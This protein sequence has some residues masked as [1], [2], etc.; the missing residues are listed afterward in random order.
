MAGRSFGLFLFV[1]AESVNG[2]LR[3]RFCSPFKNI[4]VPIVFQ[5]LKQAASSFPVGRLTF[6]NC[7]SNACTLAN[8]NAKEPCLA[9]VSDF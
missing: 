5:Q 6:E 9:A 7:G 2:F 1:L 3:V 4:H 8:E